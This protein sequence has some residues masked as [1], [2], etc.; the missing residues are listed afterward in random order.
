[1]DD[2]PVT[3]AL[4]DWAARQ[5]LGR[6]VEEGSFA[7]AGALSCAALA[8]GIGLWLPYLGF[9]AIP[10]G[11]LAVGLVVRGLWRARSRLDAERLA[12]R[13]D[14]EV[15]AEG[16][17]QTAL[18]IEGRRAVGE[19]G[20]Q[21]LVR[22]QAQTL[23]PLV[24]ERGNP[25][26][27]VPLPAIGLSAVAAVFAAL[28]VALAVLAPVMP[29]TGPAASL[30]RVPVALE[31][32]LREELAA[33]VEDLER[34]AAEPGIDPAARAA[35][36]QAR[37]AARS[38]LVHLTDARKAAGDLDVAR[39]ALERATR[40]PYRTADSLEAARTEDVA[41]A[42][43]EAL[44]RGDPALARRFADELLRRSETLESEGELRRLGRALAERQ[45][46]LGAA[47]HAMERAGE[48][49]NAGDRGGASSAFADLMAALG[50]PVLVEE[51]P[52]ELARAA[53]VVERARQRALERLARAEA[54]AR[55]EA[56][57][58]GGGRAGEGEAVDAAP[59]PAPGDSTSPAPV[60][61]PERGGGGDG[62]GGGAEGGTEDL[63]EGG[64]ATSTGDAV[65][66]QAGP[67]APRTLGEGMSDR[68]VAGD[69]AATSDLDVDG[70]GGVGTGTAQGD[71]TPSSGPGEG[72]P[73]AAPAGGA[74]QGVGS[75]VGGGAD[76]DLE[77]PKL[78]D[79]GVA[80]EW[81]RSQW[82][83]SPDAMGEL[84]RGAEAGG[85]S[86]TDWA[87]I[88]ARYRALAESA[89]RRDAV[90]LSRRQY[91]QHYFEAIRPE[92]PAESP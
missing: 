74:G 75:G 39:S 27:E 44:V 5:R 50:E 78:A 20:V 70:D 77:L 81:L 8:L 61:A 22:A 28:V 49:L 68:A 85:R 21:Q 79:A 31:D 64:N 35:V 48:A 83:S 43:D 60:G 84:V 30:P 53:E 41:N 56:G 71:G 59:A 89:S 69:G 23:L 15:G 88:H 26:I 63:I 29:A 9:L 46:P 47:G 6:I 2:L 51:R 19:G 1:M 16:L 18:A 3:R 4:E 25:P 40:G 14:E 80:A 33:S 52:A 11:I 55:G 7:A 67:D 58:R 86:S 10:L 87:A 54:E 42:L 34:L 62:G 91:I 82:A 17:L 65:S 38:G 92:P 32:D 76:L 45:R 73:G 72:A 90:P 57:E 12:R 36:E 13:L 24:E 66:T 37:D